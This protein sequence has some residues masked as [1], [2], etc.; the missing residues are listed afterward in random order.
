MIDLE[1]IMKKNGDISKATYFRGAKLP[2]INPKPCG[3]HQGTEKKVSPRKRKITISGITFDTRK[4]VE[5]HFGVS[6][7]VVAY[8]LN[9]GNPERIPDAGKGLN[10]RADAQ[11]ITIRGVTYP[12][13]RRA[14]EE[15]EIDA[16]TIYGHVKKKTLDLAGLGRAGMKYNPRKPKPNK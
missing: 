4:D 5:N 7:A 14:A 6:K 11:P 16:S 1:E 2:R 12:S 13:V 9:A 3:E 8:H 15:L 10:I